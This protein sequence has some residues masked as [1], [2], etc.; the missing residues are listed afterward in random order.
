[1]LFGSWFKNEP[2]RRG[3]GIVP[4]S[5]GYLVAVC[6]VLLGIAARYALNP[7]LGEHDAYTTFFPAVAVAVYFAGIRGGLVAMILSMLSADFLYVS[8][9]Y[10]F[11]VKGL[12]D[13]ASLGVFLLGAGIVTGFGEAMHRARARAEALRRDTDALEQRAREIIETAHEGVWMID[14]EARITMTNPRLGQMLGYSPTEMRGFHKWDFLFPSDVPRAKELFERRRRGISEQVDYRFRAKDGRE[15]WT[16]MSARPRFDEHGRFCGA[17]DM[18]SDITQRKQA[19]DALRDRETMLRMAQQAGGIGIFDWR[20][21]TR[22][23]ICSDTLLDILGRRPESG[24]VSMHEWMKWCHPADRDRMIAHLS[25]SMEGKEPCLAEYRIVRPDGKVRWVHYT[26]QIVPDSSGKPTR[27]IGTVSDITETKLRQQEL[28]T[29]VAERTAQLREMVGE[30]EVF[31]YSIAHDMRAPL[32]AMQG[33]S[34]AVL[35]DCA[36]LLPDE[37]REYLERIASSA[38]RLD[39]QILDVLSYSYLVRGQL[40][41]DN[42]EVGALVRE[43]LSTY[44]HLHSTR[45]AFE[46]SSNLPVVQA[47]RGA[48]TQVISN[49]LSNAVKFVGPG[50]IPHVK[51]WADLK[52][53]FARVHI[54]DNGIGIAPKSQQKIFGIFQRLHPAEV[55]DG[56]GI[57]LAIVKKAVARMGGEVGLISEPGK[58]SEFWFTLK[59]GTLELPLEQPMSEEEY[60]PRG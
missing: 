49:L 36:E 56:T 45:A 57:G 23:A 10:T 19:E 60:A 53:G 37:G 15:V 20:F 32:R 44:P 18:F 52:N 12:L 59:L 14:A 2:E 33:L 22:D 17:L 4:A 13:A 41:L 51:I 38:N 9:R 35:E 24:I 42:L 21:T 8:P 40:S 48:L 28:E 29:M 26:G 6:S 31:S 1:M 50:V 7:V 34:K 54:K 55:Y 5:F 47:N 30:L 3:A 16:L 25:R 39:R 58:G 11:G 43:I 46:I 27:L